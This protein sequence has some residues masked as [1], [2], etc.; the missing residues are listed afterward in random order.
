MWQLFP[1]LIFDFGCVLDSKHAQGEADK[2]SLLAYINFE[3]LLQ[4]ILSLTFFH[5]SL[6]V[7][8]AEKRQGSLLI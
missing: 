5:Y 8:L 1:P 2:F 4:V 7:E 3:K 6:H